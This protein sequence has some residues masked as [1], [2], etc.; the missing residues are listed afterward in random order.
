MKVL[1]CPEG[2]KWTTKHVAVFPSADKKPYAKWQGTAQHAYDAAV[3]DAELSVYEGEQVGP[4]LHISAHH[5]QV[6]TRK[7]TRDNFYIKVG[8]ALPSVH[9]PLVVH[10]ERGAWAFAATHKA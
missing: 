5:L 3:P 9:L 4:T 10:H 7:S 8:V 2:G 1:G 6:A